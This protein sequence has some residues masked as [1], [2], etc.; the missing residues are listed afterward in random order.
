AKLV[1]YN[2]G[3]WVLIFTAVFTIIAYYLKKEYWKDIH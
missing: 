3:I 2:I 1:R